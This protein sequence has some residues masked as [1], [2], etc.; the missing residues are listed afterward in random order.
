ML[1]GHHTMMMA[2]G[3]VRVSVIERVMQHFPEGKT[4]I[5]DHL[6]QIGKI[7]DYD[8]ILYLDDINAEPYIRRGNGRRAFEELVEYARQNGYK[9]IMGY[10][11]THEGKKFCQGVG[12][13]KFQTKY[14]K[15]FE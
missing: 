14:V 4:D 13:E 2:D 3:Q 12:M 11:A 15:C 7:D 1:P 5:A 9:C 10:A 6:M 8:Q